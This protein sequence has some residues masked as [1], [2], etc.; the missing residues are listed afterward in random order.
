MKRLLVFVLAAAVFVACNQ[1]KGAA[2][3]EMNEYKVEWSEI[4]SLIDAEAVEAE[5]FD[6]WYNTLTNSEVRDLDAAAEKL[7]ASF[8]AAEH[9][10]KNLSDADQKVALET[11]EAWEKQ[12][13]ALQLQVELFVEN[14]MECDMPLLKVYV[15]EALEEVAPVAEESVMDVEET[16]D[17]EDSEVDTE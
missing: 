3:V 12:N 14:L 17:V 4:T 16:L 2:D 8:E 13:P 6:A 5:G 10:Y 9:W 11:A 15:V 7:G 1:Q